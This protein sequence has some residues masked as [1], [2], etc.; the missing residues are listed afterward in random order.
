MATKFE[1]PFIDEQS[2]RR[3]LQQKSR[4]R[5]NDLRQL[6]KASAALRARRN[7][8][9]PQL[10]LA[11]INIDDLHFPER[12]IRKC[13]PAHVREIMGSIGTLGFCAP[14]LIGKDNLV[15]D[16]EARI[17]AAKALGL[18]TVPCVRIDHLTEAEQRALR[19]AVNRLGEKGEWD[20]AEL[21]IEF[22][23]LILTEAPI[24]ISGF[25]L[26]EIDQIILGDEAE[27]A[28][29]GP[30]APEADTVPVARRGDMFRLGA[31]RI[32]CGDAAD[33]AVLSRLMDGA[34]S[35]RLILTDEPYNV[36]IARHVTRGAHREF[37]MASGE[38]GEE[39]F[40][41]FNVNWMSAALPYLC[42]GGVFGTFIDW[43]GYPTVLAAASKRALTPV[44]V[45]VWAKNN[46]GMGS[47]YRS[48]HELLPLFKKG[49]APHVNNIELGKKGRW[50]SN[51]W[52]YPGASS[53][54]SDARRGLEDHPTVKPTAMLVDA[55]LDLTNRGD[56]VLDPFLGSGS[57]LIAAERTGRCCHGVELD[58]L[59][60]DVILRRYQS[61]TG[62]S[63]VLEATG[64][65]FGELR[66]K[67][68][69]PC[70]NAGRPTNDDDRA[71]LAACAA[72]IAAA[73]K[74]QTIAPLGAQ[75]SSPGP[76]LDEDPSA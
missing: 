69:R 31:H 14:V 32:I 30:L 73:A 59:Y 53:F 43:R 76:S 50:R 12:K 9:L 60:V 44:N 39:E 26:E 75:S 24:E 58:P 71:I 54:G 36:P 72:E 48:Q 62:K 23:E 13:T 35:A 34:P 33:P 15:L 25:S 74:T 46:A 3:Q 70:G 16:G 37:L 52:T 20:L 63:A 28:E 45:I 8:L 5:R 17:E 1:I 11:N 10:A 51:L 6:T 66:E 61:E 56:F 47:L 67:R 22:Q 49:N 27:G 2:L 38:M 68:S 41:A 64:E 18:A 19:L 29:W 4:R 21:G 57:T 40:L 42:D 65:T 7:D 55:L